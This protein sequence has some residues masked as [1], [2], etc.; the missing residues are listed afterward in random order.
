MNQIE[1]TAVKHEPSGLFLYDGRFQE[2]PDNPEVD[3]FGE[4]TD[5][6]YKGKNSEGIIDTA[7]F[8]PEDFNKVEWGDE[9]DTTDDYSEVVIKLKIDGYVV[10]YWNFYPDYSHPNNKGGYHSNYER[11]SSLP[12]AEDFLLDLGEKYRG[13]I[14]G[15]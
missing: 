2:L 11:F 9:D 14:L 10:E 15:L 13:K 12:D 7:Y 6:K 3:L 5:I 4:F 8:S 1:V